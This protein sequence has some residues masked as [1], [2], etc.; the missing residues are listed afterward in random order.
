MIAHS[1]G[2]IFWRDAEAD[3]VPDKGGRP[4][5][6]DVDEVLTLLP[7]EGLKPAEWE[8]QAKAECGVRGT[9]FHRIRRLLQSSNRIAKSTTSGK[10]QPVLKP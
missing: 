9:S 1:T 2:S 8:A 6:L 4:K 5:Q 7:P 10:W 3:E